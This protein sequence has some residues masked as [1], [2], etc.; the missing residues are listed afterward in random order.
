M[1]FVRIHILALL[2]CLGK[3]SQAQ[4]AVSVVF[5]IK[6]TNTKEIEIETFRFYVS[7]FQLLYTD[8]THEKV[9]PICYLIDIEDEE[10][11]SVSIPT[12]SNKAI[13]SISYL[14]GTDS[15]TNVSGAL[16]GD[17]DPIKGMYWAWN[18]GY[19]NFKLEGTRTVS[20]KK[21]PFEYHIGG[22]NGIQATARKKLID[23]EQSENSFIN[24][25]VNPYSFIE[26]AESIDAFSI[27]IPGNK[28][29]QLADFLPSI[30]TN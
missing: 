26:S 25:K 23:I 24:I 4:Q 20:G 28:A 14:I 11:Q 29:V 30:F 2:L 12:N 13:E 8:G 21:T 16:D 18:S 22:Y 7:N 19:I 1:I 3:S 9:N 27:M 10:S 5:N 15:L 17:L 6:S